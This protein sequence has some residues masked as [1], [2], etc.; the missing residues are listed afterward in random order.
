MLDSTFTSSGQLAI[1][2][3]ALVTM[4]TT[5]ATLGYQ[6][7]REGRRHRWEEEAARNAASAETTL[8][9][10]LQENT[11]ISRQAFTEANH[12]NEKLA[13][14]AANFDKLLAVAL[15]A[16]EKRSTFAAE[17]R[18]ASDDL[19]SESAAKDLKAVKDTVDGTAGQ[20]N[21]IHVAV[22]ENGHRDA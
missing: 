5:F 11:D 6:F 10:K 15:A 14:Q 21:D 4:L 1:L 20:V 7:V 22:V 8:H 19:R 13:I 18:S 12:V 9:A 3:T 2:V 17:V 16:S